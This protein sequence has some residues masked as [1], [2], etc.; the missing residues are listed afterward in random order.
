[1]PIVWTLR[2]ANVYP[3]NIIKLRSNRCYPP[4]L[5]VKSGGAHSA[6]Y[7]KRV[8]KTVKSKMP[9]TCVVFSCKNVILLLSA[10]HAQVLRVIYSI[11]YLPSP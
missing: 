7:W 2:G 8:T 4:I 9:Q 6:R 3:M 1:M 11:C 10:H 5:V